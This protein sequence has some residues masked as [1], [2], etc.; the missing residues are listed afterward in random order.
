MCLI[1][2]NNTYINA[3]ARSLPSY[4]EEQKSCLVQDSH[5]CLLEGQKSSPRQQENDQTEMEM[6]PNVLASKATN[7]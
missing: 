3:H 6:H 2:H 7:M 1:R 5:Q 4:E